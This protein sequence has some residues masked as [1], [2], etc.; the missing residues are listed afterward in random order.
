[1]EMWRS[2][3]SCSTVFCHSSVTMD[4]RFPRFQTHVP[5]LL[6]LVVSLGVG[7]AKGTECSPLPALEGAAAATETCL[8]VPSSAVLKQYV[9]R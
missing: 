2:S 7:Q 4:R 9:L 8:C 1:M 6:S 5:P 3:W